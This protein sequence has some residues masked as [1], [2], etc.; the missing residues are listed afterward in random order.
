MLGIEFDHFSYLAAV[1]QLNITIV[2]SAAAFFFNL[3]LNY[4]LIRRFGIVGAG[5][6]SSLAYLTD[7]AIRGIYYFKLYKG[8]KKMTGFKK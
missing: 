3:V 7:V 1:N 6:A 8:C 4:Y 2:A 5:I